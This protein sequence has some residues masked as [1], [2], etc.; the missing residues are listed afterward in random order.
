MPWQQLELGG[1]PA[2]THYFL[3]LYCNLVSTFCALKMS[4]DEEELWVMFL[5]CAS[6]NLNL[7]FLAQ[8]CE[9]VARVPPRYWYYCRWMHFHWRWCQSSGNPSASV[10]RHYRSRTIL[11]FF[12]ITHCT[13]FPVVAPLHHKMPL[14][15]SP[16]QYNLDS[17]W[18]WFHSPTSWWFPGMGYR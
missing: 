5:L 12:A 7:F 14:F 11:Q 15:C 3:L 2:Q 10:S 8:A 13:S 1:L 6:H 16:Q 4:S 18:P 9:P 17:Y